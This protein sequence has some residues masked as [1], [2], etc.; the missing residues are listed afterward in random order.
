VAGRVVL[1]ALK[2][3][4]IRPE[5]VMASVVLAHVVLQRTGICTTNSL[6]QRLQIKQ[7]HGSRHGTISP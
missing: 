1:N 6:W 7:K 5:G 3:L 4:R 2:A